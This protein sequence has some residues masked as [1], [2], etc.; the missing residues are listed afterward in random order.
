MGG[1]QIPISHVADIRFRTGPPMLRNEGGHLVGFVF[2]DVGEDIGIADYVALAQEVV[3]ERVAVPSGY[4]V[5]WAGQYQHFERA[6]ERLRVLVPLTL[7]IVFF[8]LYAHR[9][10]VGDAL[11]VMAMV[12]FALTGSVWLVYLLGYK[13]SVAVWVGM[14][15]MAGLAAEMGLLML[16][17]LDHALGQA[18]ARGEVRDHRA[19]LGALTQGAGQ[20]IRPMLMTSTTL[21]ASLV[22]VMLSDGTGSDVMQRIAAPMLGGIVSALI[23]VLLLMPSVFALWQTYRL[24]APGD[25]RLGGSLAAE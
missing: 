13:L 10:R 6:R 25:R 5:A 19:L 17:Y 2:V 4:R 16:F 9:G 7:L 18:R 23:V 22:P 15:A 1:R 21:V 20:R 14:I 24:P 12:P 11:F 8:M 3:A